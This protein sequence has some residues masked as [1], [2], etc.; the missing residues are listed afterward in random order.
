[1]INMFE[2]TGEICGLSSPSTV[3]QHL[4]TLK[5]ALSII[6][7]ARRPPVC[8]HLGQH[9]LRQVDPSARSFRD[10]RFSRFCEQPLDV[11]IEYNSHL[12][13]IQS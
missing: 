8:I 10:A 1:M 2:R 3:S 6:L 12:A 5:R 7:M 13:F 9:D 11:L 4:Q